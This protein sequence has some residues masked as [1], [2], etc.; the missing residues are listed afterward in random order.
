MSPNGTSLRSLRCKRLS[1]V[2]C[3]AD[4]GPLSPWRVS[5]K[6]DDQLAQSSNALSRKDDYGAAPIPWGFTISF[7]DPTQ[8]R[9]PNGGDGHVQCVS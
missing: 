8:P 6:P 3:I 5:V 9:L 1:R 7:C 2:G 4:I